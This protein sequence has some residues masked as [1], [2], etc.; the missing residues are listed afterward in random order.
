MKAL[1]NRMGNWIVTHPRL[2]TIAVFAG[3]AIAATVLMPASDFARRR[4]KP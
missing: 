1:L 3:L 2:V 4:I